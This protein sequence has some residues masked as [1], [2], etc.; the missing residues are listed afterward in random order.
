LYDDAGN[1]QDDGSI[2]STYSG[3]NRLVSTQGALAPTLYQYNAFGERVSK[4]SSTQTLFAY[5][6]Q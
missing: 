5:D 6:E 4:Q 3:R 1:L 2:S